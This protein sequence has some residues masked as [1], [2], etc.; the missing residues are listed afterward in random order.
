VEKEPCWDEENKYNEYTADKNAVKAR[1]K[2]NFIDID[3]IVAIRII[4]VIKLMEG[5]AAI[6]AIKIKNN[7]KEYLGIIVIK[8][9]IK[10]N[11]REFDVS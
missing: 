8:P 7:H 1:I 4:S 2:V 3:V 10:N 6:L 11:L 5:G 9:L